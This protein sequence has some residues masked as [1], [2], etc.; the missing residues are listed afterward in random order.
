MQPPG[1]YR[2]RPMGRGAQEDPRGRLVS[3]IAVSPQS[4][5]AGIL[6]IATQSTRPLA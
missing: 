2:K 1:S 3:R 5:R 4:A 6:P